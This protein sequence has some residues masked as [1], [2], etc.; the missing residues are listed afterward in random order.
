[1]RT[2]KLVS[3]AS[4]AALTLALAASAAAH[5]TVEPTEAPS[6][7]FAKLIFTIPH[8]CDGSSSTRLR[9]QI[10]RSV[11]SVTPGVHPSW[12]LSV[13]QGPKDK[14]ELFGETITRGVSEV[15]WTATEPLPDPFLEEFV[16][17][18]KLPKGEGE[19]LYFP[20]IQECEKG[21]T[22]WIEIPEPGETEDDLE[23]PAPAVTLVAAEEGGHGGGSEEEAAEA[24]PA[25]AEADEDEDEDS[26][27]LAIAALIV[28]GLGLV[29]GTGALFRSR[30]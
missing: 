26:N 13:K 14:T 4:V 7:G 24:E 12:D 19:T 22:R 27:G 15:T 25:S 30:S 29:V 10:P 11:P 23:S 28:G 16:I 3:A 17:E 2:I 1:M 8:G 20:T 6:D 9:V 21:Q 18:V 5:V